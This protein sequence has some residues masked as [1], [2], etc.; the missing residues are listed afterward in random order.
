MVPA[1]MMG[2][3]AAFLRLIFGAMMTIKNRNPL[4]PRLHF[5]VDEAGQ[6]GHAEFLKRAYTYGRGVGI[7]SW[8]FWQD[9]GQISKNF[10]PEG[11]Q[12]FLGS[13]EVRQVLGVRDGGTSRLISDMLGTQTVS[14]TDPHRYAAAQDAKRRA[15]QAFLAGD[16]PMSALVDAAHHRKMAHLPNAYDRPL[17]DPAEV[18]NMSQNEQV[19]LISGR[20]C[21]PIRAGREHYWTRREMAGLFMPKGPGTS[22]LFFGELK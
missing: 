4:S 10:G 17:L 13:A 18:L 1:E 19:L 9:L 16:D 21:P 22:C 6:L 14:Y 11:I 2:I 12:T 15:H 20:N 5:F 3:W 7:R 8:S